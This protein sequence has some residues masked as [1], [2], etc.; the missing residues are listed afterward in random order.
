H[1]FSAN[2]FRRSKPRRDEK[3]ATDWLAQAA[4]QVIATSAGE[5]DR[6]ALTLSVSSSGSGTCKRV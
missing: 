1:V 3:G 4:S 6:L 5:Y 2:A